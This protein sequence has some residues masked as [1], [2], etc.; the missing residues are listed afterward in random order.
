MKYSW[1][2]YTT[3][4][5]D[6]WRTY[7]AYQKHQEIVNNIGDVNKNQRLKKYIIMHHT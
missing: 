5:M 6:K 7:L 3:S 4:K 2:I 1:I